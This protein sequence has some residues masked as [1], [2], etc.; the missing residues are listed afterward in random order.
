MLLKAAELVMY[1]KEL[2]VLLFR[3]CS[4][5]FIGTGLQFKCSNE[6]LLLRL[7]VCLSWIMI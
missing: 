1:Y 2:L 5:Q 7:R 4:C 3:Y 6:A